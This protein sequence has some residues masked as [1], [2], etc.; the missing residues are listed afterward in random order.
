MNLKIDAVASI[1]CFH[2]CVNITLGNVLLINNLAK[3]GVF[4]AALWFNNQ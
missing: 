1:Y 4:C 3:A 2:A